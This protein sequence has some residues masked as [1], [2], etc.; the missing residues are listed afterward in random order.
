MLD[1][2]HPRGE[3]LVRRDQGVLDLNGHADSDKFHTGIG[4]L[5]LLRALRLSR[6]KCR[7]LSLAVQLLALGEQRGR[8]AAYLQRLER[9]IDLVACHL[10]TQQRV[11]QFHLGGAT[12]DADALQRLMSQLRKR[13]N[14]I[15]HDGG[16]YRVEVDLHHTD[17][18]TMGLLRELGFNQ[19][20]IGVPDIGTDSELSVAC[21][22]NPAPIHSLIDAARTFGYRS[23]NVDLGYGHAW[24]T[25][26]SFALKLATL[27]ELEPDRL[28]VFDYAQPPRRYRRE[29]EY[30]RA[31]SS[32]TDKAAMRRI[33]FEQLLAAGY[34]Y[35]GLGQFVRSD[36]DLLLAQERG[37]LR[38]NCQGFTC[39][40]YCDHVGFGLGAISQLDEL[41]VQNSEALSDYLQQL[42]AGQL[43]SCRGWRCEAG[44]Q[45]RQR[46]RE[47]LECDLEL[48]V[49]AIES[50]YGVI[51]RQ[52][53][54]AAWPRLEHMARDGLV[55]LSERFISILPAGRRELDAICQLFDA[56]VNRPAYSA[57]HEFVEHDAYL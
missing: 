14:F 29:N 41:S 22:Q 15:E 24:Q 32:P 54:S 17:W 5:D 13:F 57:H 25:P 37:R 6:Q 47:R 27:I 1:L 11:E 20:S 8:S 16:D 10:G 26:S 4:S 30:R 3:R 51:F 42:D 50:R 52:Y 46:V 45:I 35:I 18:A 43:A 44:D 56:D 21:Y 19:V 28:Q 49:L 55:E 12:P 53:F 36:D 7:P 34:Q 31:A 38:R 39:H 48:D 2:P 23:V 40:G 33:C 9:E